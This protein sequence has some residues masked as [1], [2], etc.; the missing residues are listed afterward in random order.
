MR[1]NLSTALMVFCLLTV[2]LNTVY[3]GVN[4]KTNTPKFSPPLST[5][6]FNADSIPPDSLIK[7]AQTLIGSRYRSASSSP[8]Y[9][10]D[11]SGFVDYVFK[12]FNFDVPRSSREFINIG[13]KIKLADAKPGDVILFTSPHKRSRRIGHVGIVFCNADGEFQFIHC[14]SGKEHGV[15][16][17]AMDEKYKRRFVQVVRL[18]K[19]NDAEISIK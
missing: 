3:S 14:T 5:S 11:C 1:K 17:T 13:K 8:L 12:S 15:T 7:F 4:N 19:L 2:S 6:R 16:I 10:F 9:G 18:L